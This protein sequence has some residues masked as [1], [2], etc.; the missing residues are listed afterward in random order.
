MVLGCYLAKV[1]GPDTYI[2]L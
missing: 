1:N 2:Q